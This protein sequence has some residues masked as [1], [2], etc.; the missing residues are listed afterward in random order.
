MIE[1]LHQLAKR[2]IIDHPVKFEREPFMGPLVDQQ[3]MDKYLLFM[4]MAK[5]EGL[6]EI[7]RGKQIEKRFKGHYVSPSIHCMP[8]FRHE[9]VF[10]GSEIFGPNCTFI[11]YREIE[12]AITIANSTEYGLATGV[13]TKD[14]A[15]YQQCVQDIDAGVV[16]LNRSTVG[17]SARLPFGGV[18][19]SGNYRPAA[20]ATIDACVYQM[21]GL[22]A[23]APTAEDINSIKGLA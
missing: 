20:L 23:K 4:G 5:R 10:V 19:N 8:K 17:S 18:K 12:E 6:E 22:E 16:N 1:K 2:I 14:M 13:F 21:A 11:P 3:S 15:V 7:M 9:S